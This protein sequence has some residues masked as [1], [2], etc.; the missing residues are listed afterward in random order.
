LKKG[1]ERKESKKEK[2]KKE[3]YKKQFNS[4]CNFTLIEHEIGSRAVQ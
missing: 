2:K 1:K 4:S 3:R